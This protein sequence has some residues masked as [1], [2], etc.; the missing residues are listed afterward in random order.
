MKNPKNQED[1]KNKQGLKSYVLFSGVAIQMGATIFAGAYLGKFLD[2]KYEIEAKWFTIVLTLASV[3][4]S[5]YNVLRQVNR[6]NK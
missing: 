2:H 4:L 1:Q 6:L 5:L 3:G